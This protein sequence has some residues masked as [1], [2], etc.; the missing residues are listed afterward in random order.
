MA[1]FLFDKVESRE[2]AMIYA[3]HES[4]HVLTILFLTH[5]DELNLDMLIEGKFWR[6]NSKSILN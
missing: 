6:L 4:L 5:T 1:E 2:P 3:A